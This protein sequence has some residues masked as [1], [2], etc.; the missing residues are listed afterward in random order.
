MLKLL[1]GLLFGF[2]LGHYM[3]IQYPGVLPERLTQLFSAVAARI[4]TEAARDPLPPTNRAS[5][6][7]AEFPVGKSDTPIPLSSPPPMPLSAGDGSSG[8]GETLRRAQWA[9]VR[10][11]IEKSREGHP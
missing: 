2:C 11:V 6:P 5:A 4:G 3:A 8:E 9:E 7:T 1:F 10:N